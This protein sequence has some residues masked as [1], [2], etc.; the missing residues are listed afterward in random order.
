LVRSGLS[1]SIICSIRSMFSVGD[2][3]HLGLAALEQRRAVHPGQ[4]SRLGGQLP[5][6]G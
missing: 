2:A 1:V 6:V 5:D 4:R 3:Q